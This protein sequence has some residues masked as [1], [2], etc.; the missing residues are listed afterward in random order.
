M[1]R[2]S[3][4]IRKKKIAE[5]VN[6]KSDLKVFKINFQLRDIAYRLNSFI[7]LI[8]KCFE[9]FFL[10]KTRNLKICNIIQ[11]D[12]GWLLLIR[13][14]IKV[15]VSR[16]MDTLCV[17][18]RTSL[19]ENL[20]R[21]LGD[22]RYIMENARGSLLK[23]KKQ[24]TFV[25]TCTT[26][27]EHNAYYVFLSTSCRCGKTYQHGNM[28]CINGCWQNF[29]ILI[30]PNTSILI[31]LTFYSS[32]SHIRYNVQTRQIQSEFLSHDFPILFDVSTANTY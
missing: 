4:S 20:E 14:R 32:S 24:P 16:N 17:A 25:Q 10:V 3:L 9:L 21:K 19:V 8:F 30:Q 15:E 13:S 7:V 27:S 1:V 28:Y 29:K 23:K 18:V 12:T 11:I 6:F 22:L 2:H 5:K 31:F 26:L